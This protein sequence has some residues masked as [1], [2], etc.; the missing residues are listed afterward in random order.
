MEELLI[1]AVS[2][3]TAIPYLALQFIDLFG[4]TFNEYSIQVSK[5][6]D[7]YSL[8]VYDIPDGLYLIEIKTHSQSYFKKIMIKK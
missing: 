4:T 2:I 7:H 3:R 1:V 6:M 5:G 8:D